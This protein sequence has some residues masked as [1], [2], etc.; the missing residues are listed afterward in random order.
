MMQCIDY[1]IRLYMVHVTTFYQ[2]LFIIYENV[3]QF[4]V[5]IINIQ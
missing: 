2:T 4:L 3:P 1:G 5:G